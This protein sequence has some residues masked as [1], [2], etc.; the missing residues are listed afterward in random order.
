V[1]EGRAFE[2]ETTNIDPEIASVP[3]PQLVVPVMNARYAINAANAQFG[4][5]YGTD[6]IGSRPKPGGYDLGR[7]ARVVTRVRVIFDDFFP[8]E[9]ASHVDS[10]S[11]SVDQDGLSVDGK[12]LEDPS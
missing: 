8:L 11:Y 12:R 9:G 4:S 5:L 2:I 1:P 7:G 3:G 6:A 10:K